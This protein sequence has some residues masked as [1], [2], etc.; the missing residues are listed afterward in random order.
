M[1]EKRTRLRIRIFELL[2][3]VTLRKPSSPR[4]Q[5][6]C[7]YYLPRFQLSRWSRGRFV[8]K[9]VSSHHDEKLVLYQRNHLYLDEPSVTVFMTT[10]KNK[11]SKSILHRNFT[12]LSLVRYPKYED[13]SV[14]ELIMC[15][16]I[17]QPL[18]KFHFQEWYPY[19]GPPS[20]AS[21]AYNGRKKKKNNSIS[22]LVQTDMHIR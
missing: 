12:V 2:E 10:S 16:V 15:D 1:F 7:F 4:E 18:G 6:G 22:S 3:I 21:V 19:I 13:S 9:Y 17:G 20:K 11:G 14:I 5:K 8:K